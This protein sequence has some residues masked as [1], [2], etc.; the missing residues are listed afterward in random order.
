[1]VKPDKAAGEKPAMQTVNGQ[2]KFFVRVGASLLASIILGGLVSEAQAEFGSPPGQG[3]PKG[4]AGGGSRP[5]PTTCLEEPTSGDTLVTMAPTQ[6]VGL[7]SQASPTVWV[8]IPRTRAKLLE[9]SLFTDQQDGVYQTNLP[10]SSPGLLK[11]ALP[12]QIALT[13]GK[14]YRWTVALVCNANQRT[15]DWIA[16]GWIQHQSLNAELQ[17]QL[18][19]ATIEQRI[20]LYNQSD[21]WY[22]AFNAYLTLWQ[23]QPGNPNLGLIQ[24]DLL[25]SAGLTAIANPFPRTLPQAPVPCNSWNGQF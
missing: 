5:T 16:E 7:T 19:H 22:E 14:P 11:I 21:F 2:W 6:F 3:R 17:R 15:E 4:T 13:T 24:A 12:P 18:S 20:M 8:Q 10:I 25:K 23:T 1:V 9:F